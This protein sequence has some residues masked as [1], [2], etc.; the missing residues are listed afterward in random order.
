[1]K[2]L[3]CEMCGGTNLIKKDGMFVCQSCNTKYST[4][5]A[6]KMMGEVA[7]RIESSVKVVNTDKI[8]NFVK[9]AKSAY[10]A[11]NYQEAETY[12]NKVIEI[13]FKNSYAHYLKGSSILYGMEVTKT[14]CPEVINYFS[15]AIDYSPKDNP[16]QHNDAIYKDI[17]FMSGGLI[18]IAINEI[19]QEETGRDIDNLNN[20]G[21]AWGLVGAGMN[22][23]NKSTNTNALA[24]MIEIL[25]K[26]EA[27]LK[28]LK[29]MN[30]PIDKYERDSANLLSQES[31]KFLAK[32]LKNANSALVDEAKKTSSSGG[33]YIATSI[34]NSYDCPQVWV[35][36]RFRDHTLESYW[37]GKTFIKIYYSISPTIVKLFGKQV[38]FNNFFKPQLNK[39]VDKLKDKGIADTPYRD[40]NY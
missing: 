1:M 29:K 31:K 5:D 21:S 32:R 34:Y 27:T 40:K 2:Q 38:W 13:D 8:W 35:L 7:V 24:Q 16:T 37:Y 12:A 39:L 9:M 10:E 15:N 23:L 6:K 19:T 36:R 4:E 26:S 30:I 14:R 17:T 18:Q 20:I 33:C 25:T 22:A 28:L 3:T 11:Q